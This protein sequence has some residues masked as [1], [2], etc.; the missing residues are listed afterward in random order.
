MNA[1][2]ESLSALEYAALLVAAPATLVM[3]IQTALLLFGIHNEGD[4]DGDFDDGDLDLDADFDGDVDVDGD[5]DMDLDLD[6]DAD[7]D[8]DIDNA[9]TDA[10]GAEDGGPGLFAGLRVLTLRG[11][12]AFLAIFGWGTLWLLRVGLHPAIA[13][14]FGV[15]MGIWAMILVAI[16][17][18]LALQLQEDGTVDIQNALGLSGTVYLTVPAARQGEGKVHLVVQDQLRE[19]QAVTDEPQDIPTGT[20]VRVMGVSGRDTL[21]VEPK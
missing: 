20:P 4:G 17:L 21:V 8:V 7:G 3:L 11:I 16:L 13:L 6:G 15:A 5:L 10:D 14:F 1:W 18:R 12:V 9:D 19:L 2:L